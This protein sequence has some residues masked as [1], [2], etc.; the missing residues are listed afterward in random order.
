MKREKKDVAPETP[1]ADLD[2][3]DIGLPDLDF[4]F[5][6]SLFDVLNDG[7]CEE[8]RY[9]KPQIRPVRQ[10]YICYDNAL[11]LAADLP[12]DYGTRYD[13]F[14]GGSFI[15]G[16][17]LEAF[18]TRNNA[19]C[20][21]LLISTLSLNQNNVDS[22][23]NLM[24]L[25]YVDRLDLIVSA[26]FYSHEAHSLIPYMHE[27]LDVGDRFQLAVASVHT[28]TAQF[29]TLGGRKVIIHGSA[30]L[31]SSGNIEQFTLEE[32]AGL[33]DFYAEHFDRIIER[34]A[35]IRKAI[36]HKELW[37]TFN[38]DKKSNTNKERR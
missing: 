30:N 28:K 14:V 21:R 25:G 33:Y 34:Y 1:V 13:V 16:D 8:T 26:Y 22:L 11:K 29:E 2:F 31:R 17:F 27:H 18:I 3:G 7:F 37:Q 10:G 12:L 9:V 24:Q 15:F 35:T 36:R 23:A 5:D 20:L 19:K 4:D 38:G 6:T 32:N